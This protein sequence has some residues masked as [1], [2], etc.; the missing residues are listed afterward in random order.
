MTLSLS[1]SDLVVRAG[2][3][4]LLEVPSLHVPAGTLVG[5]RGPSGAGKSTF[6]HALAGLIGANGSIK[7]GETDIAQLSAERRT[8]FRAATMGMIFQDFLLFDEL[9]A[10]ANACLAGLFAPASARKGVIARAEDRLSTLNVP[11][12][13]R[14]VASFSG[15]ER[16]RVA[17]ARALATDPEI[18][19]A[20]EPTASLDRRAADSLIEDLVT[21]T[22]NSGSTLIA[23]SHDL[24]LLNQLDR[25]LAIEDGA[26]SSD[27]AGASR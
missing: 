6:L 25:V 4:C 16:Q 1:I 17:I 21:L 22:R 20:D 13:A 9:S 14:S 19:L 3:R 23:V 18:L 11:R 27:T 24:T 5:V 8:A 15:G 2:A 26:L 10:S 12:D 7:W